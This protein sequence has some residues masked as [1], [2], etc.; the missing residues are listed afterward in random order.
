MVN[1]IGYMS[2]GAVGREHVE[3]RVVGATFVTFGYKDTAR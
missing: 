1:H 3:N 2:A